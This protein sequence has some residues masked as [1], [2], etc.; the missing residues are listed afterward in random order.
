MLPPANITIEYGTNGGLFN[1]QIA[2]INAL[3]IAIGMGA[4]TLRWTPFQDRSTFAKNAKR[5]SWRWKAASDVYDVDTIEKQLAGARSSFAGACT[6]APAVP[7][8]PG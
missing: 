7:A 2:T 3:L 6:W 5:Q 1:Q 8:V 4:T